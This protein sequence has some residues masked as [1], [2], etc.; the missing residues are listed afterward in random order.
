MNIA[1]LLAFRLIGFGDGTRGVLLNPSLQSDKL[2]AVRTRIEPL[3]LV[4]LELAF[5]AI[6]AIAKSFAIAWIVE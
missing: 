3:P 2:I 5:W 1:M 4:I 6:V